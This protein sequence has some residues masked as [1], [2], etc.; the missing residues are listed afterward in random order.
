M[1]VSYMLHVV[2]MLMLIYDDVFGTPTNPQ[3]HGT[4]LD[5]YDHPIQNPTGQARCCCM[6]T[7]ERKKSDLII[8]LV[9]GAQFYGLFV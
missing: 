2:F 4:C 8:T 3:I 7:D 1:V 5:L 6:Y 9:I